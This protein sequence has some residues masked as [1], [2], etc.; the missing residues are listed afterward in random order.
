MAGFDDGDDLP[1]RRV[2]VEKRS[3]LKGGKRKGDDDEEVV[4]K[5]IKRRKAAGKEDRYKSS[6]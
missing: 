1:L 3:P 5:S 6:D 2:K 4:M